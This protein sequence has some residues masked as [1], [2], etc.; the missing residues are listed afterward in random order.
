[1]ESCR[2]RYQISYGASETPENIGGS[3]ISESLFRYFPVTD[4]ALRIGHQK[5]P[6][7]WYYLFDDYRLTYMLEKAKEELPASMLC[8]P[9]IQQLRSYDHA[10]DTEL[11]ETLQAYL[12]CNLNMTA[13]AERLYIHRTTF[14]RRMNHIR[15]L[16]CLDFSDP[17]TT[18]TLLLSYRL[19][20]L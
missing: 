5:Q 11:A 20:S 14:C 9:A 8:H 2:G 7:F 13:A 15:K 1:M 12:Q 10:N 3:P 18:P 6:Y 16:T 4:A 17:D 19:N